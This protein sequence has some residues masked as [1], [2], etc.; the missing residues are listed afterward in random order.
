MYI[1]RFKFN[2]I[3]KPLGPLSLTNCKKEQHLG[4]ASIFMIQCPKCGYINHVKTSSEH[5]TGKRGPKSFDI[6]SRI[7]LGCLHAGIGQTHINNLLATTN[8]PGLTNNTFKHREREVGLAVEKV[9]KKSCKQVINDEKIIALSNGIQ[10]DENKVLSVAC[11]F[12]MG[13]QKR[14]KGHNSNTGQAAVM[15]E[16]DIWES[17]GLYNRE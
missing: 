4:L 9:A 3:V 13:W 6:N 10:S 2:S 15:H 16:Y 7:V 5:R 12:D 1:R 14:G 11:S 17:N 8:I